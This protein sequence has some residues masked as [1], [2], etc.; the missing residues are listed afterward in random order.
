M[1]IKLS[2]IQTI[3]KGVYNSFDIFKFLRG[4]RL[5][6]YLS[7]HD[8]DGRIPFTSD[9]I[10]TLLSI[11]KYIND[12]NGEICEIIVYGKFVKIICDKRFEFHFYGYDVSG[13]SLYH[14]S[15]FR[16]FFENPDEIYFREIRT[17]YF[18]RLNNNGLFY[19]RSDAD[20]FASYIQLHNEEE[21]F[22]QDGRL[23]PIMIYNIEKV[24][25]LY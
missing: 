23:F 7:I 9:N 13:D 6:E 24:T 17:C 19:D 25:S 15:V 1:F 12:L 16:A 8:A 2:S 14:S 4:K 18:N 11:V 10:N 5:K 21:V 20:E 3:Y 22:E